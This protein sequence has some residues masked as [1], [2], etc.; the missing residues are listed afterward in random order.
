MTNH[1]RGRSLG[2]SIKSRFYFPFYL[3]R[4]SIPFPISSWIA[5]YVFPLAAN[6]AE[7]NNK[8]TRQFFITKTRL[9]SN[10]VVFYFLAVYTK[11][12]CTSCFAFLLLK[13]ETKPNWISV[14]ILAIQMEN[15]FPKRVEVWRKS[16][17]MFPLQFTNRKFNFVDCILLFFFVYHYLKI[18]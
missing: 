10:P 15:H 4:S 3:E 1:P 13:A 6:S 12:H 5:S 8:S 9:F 11:I 16:S 2:I 17:H 7:W 18:R 14:S